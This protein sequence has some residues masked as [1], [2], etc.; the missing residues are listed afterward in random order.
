MGDSVEPFGALAFAYLRKT[1]DA[2]PRPD[3]DPVSMTDA[4]TPP[5]RVLIADDDAA[6]ARILGQVVARDDSMD[7]VGAAA[8]AEEAVALAAESR[9][10]VAILDVN[11]PGGGGARAAREIGERSP[12]TRIVALSGGGGEEAVLEMLAAG[13]GGYVLKG[14][15]ARELHDAVLAAG[16]GE[17]L[18]STRVASVV[19]TALRRR[20][21]RQERET[22]RFD[23][24]RARIEDVIG[25]GLSMALQPI[26][27]LCNGVV[28]GYEA[29]PRFDGRPRQPADVWLR[30]AE[31]VGLRTELDL[32]ALRLAI[33]ALPDVPEDAFVVIGVGPALASSP[34]LPEA[35]PAT[36]GARVVL[37]L[38]DHGGVRDYG[39]LADALQGL[40]ER[41]VRLALDDTGA[42]LASLQH[43]AA[44][45]PEFV[46]LDRSLTRN[47][48]HDPT[49]RALAFALLSF[50]AQTGVTVIAD[51]IE[52]RAELGA[53]R[54]LGAG[55]GRGYLI[56]RPLQLPPLHPL[57]RRLDLPPVP[58]QLPLRGGTAGA[59]PPARRFR[60]FLD[61]VRVA[62]DALER[63]LAGSVVMLGHLDHSTRVLRVLDA[64]A[65]ADLRLEPGRTFVIDEA[66]CYHMASGRGPRLCGDIASEPVYAALPLVLD[67][68]AVSY[69]GAPLELS[70]GTAI[71]ALSALNPE[72]DAFDEAAFEELRTLAA[73]LAATLEHD[74][75]GDPQMLADE[76][77]RYATID[78]LTGATNAMG[79]REV[80]AHQWRR[81]HRDGVSTYVVRVKVR[82][83]DAVNRRYG[84]T[85]GDLLLKDLAAC[86][87]ASGKFSDIVGRL[88]GSEFGAVLVGCS[89]DEGASY[90]CKALSGRLSEQL[91][92]RELDA[93]V[94]AG[95]AAL[96][97]AG[98]PE[99][100][101]AMAAER[102]FKVS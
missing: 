60:T 42:G 26:V 93:D 2:A 8:D 50:A 99:E 49:R 36:D 67:A 78:W 77:R 64:R 84:R 72:L 17:S 34:L 14:G 91:R 52:T 27:D 69:A 4:G 18:L 81:A 3:A 24:V 79:L 70:D 95:V 71:G 101:I 63:K 10:D 43:I 55:Y 47:V 76:L 68:D 53:L 73:A 33:E 74:H 45:G 6:F 32:A 54:G 25:G 96:G 13:A 66:P 19:V 31:E 57:P 97:E 86:L 88:G 16:R 41:G 5:L 87:E 59:R 65:P 38:T 94:V 102:P 7:L 75:P 98:S 22:Q 90:F 30:E 40:R 56:G 61:G 20:V 11:M 80:I 23:R 1:G 28:Q 35:I 92:R 48:D 9:P 51:G 82:D 39:V 15:S 44:I 29:L 37:E 89:R 100:A 46:K 62:L 83:L 85:L 58:N 21:E 12:R